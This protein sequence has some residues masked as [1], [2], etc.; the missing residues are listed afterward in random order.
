[1]SDKTPDYERRKYRRLQQ[2]G[3]IEP[4]CSACGE[5]DWRCMEGHHLADHG[6]DDM[7]GIVCRNCHRKLSDDQLDHPRFD[8]AADPMLDAIGHFLL[9]LADLLRLVV[10]KLL[11]FGQTLIARAGTASVEAS[12]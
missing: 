10:E 1:M 3:T 7:T 8:P 2:L 4:I 12:A 6:R 9:G 11:A 5:R